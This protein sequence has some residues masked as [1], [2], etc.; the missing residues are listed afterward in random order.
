MLHIPEG[1]KKEGIYVS[2]CSVW[3]TAALRL[4]LLTTF[5]KTDK[6]AGG[7]AQRLR[8]LGYFS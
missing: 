2:N 6:G 7:V 5:I 1:L 4:Q 8:A 3:S